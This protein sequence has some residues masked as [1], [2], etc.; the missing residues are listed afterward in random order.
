MKLETALILI[1]R[2]YDRLKKGSCTATRQDNGDKIIE[3]LSICPEAQSYWEY[4]GSQYYWED[5]F[6]QKASFIPS[7]SI[8]I[9]NKTL[10]DRRF[11]ATK[12]ALLNEGGVYLIATTSIDIA[13][14]TIYY[15]V[16][17]GCSPTDLNKR[18]SQYSTYNPM[19]SIVDY[20]YCSNAREVEGRYKRALTTC[21]AVAHH[22]S[23]E[24]KCVTKEFYE[25]LLQK[26]LSFFDASN[27]FEYYLKI[28]TQESHPI[29]VQEENDYIEEDSVI[30]YKRYVSI[31]EKF[32]NKFKKNS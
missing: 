1:E 15:W 26:K 11:T 27:W 16:K 28:R 20:E 10:I 5:R 19:Y 29:E 31:V 8:V 14:N 25:I 9:Q 21:G 3:I 30:S 23:T 6:K 18:L 7:S 2:Y 24:W 13:T 12:N 22:F 32:F 4:D 17:I